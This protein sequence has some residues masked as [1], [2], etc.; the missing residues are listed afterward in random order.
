M[1]VLFRAI[2]YASLFI[3]LLLV[4]LPARVL[5][6]SGIVAPANLGI[7][8]VVGMVVGGSGAVVAIWS[9]VTFVAIGRGTPAPFDPPQR[10]VV[11]GPYRVVR[12]PMYCG[13]A[14]ALSGAA[15][16][17]ESWALLL[18]TAAF[19]LLMHAFVVAYEEPTLR[20]TFGAP[21]LRYCTSV[22]RWWPSANRVEISD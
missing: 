8:Q 1:F 10:L 4:F 20:A 17:Y 3:G 13:A 15:L 14:L 7:A 2:T 22:H 21:Y 9:I 16:F 19:A 12:N 11:V 18:Y 5:S 6:W